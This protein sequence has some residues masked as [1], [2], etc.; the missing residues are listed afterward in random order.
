MDL[1]LNVFQL[2]Q[3]W[4]SLLWQKLT[5]LRRER[6]KELNALA[7]IFGDPV[8]LARFY[9]EPDCQQV[10][11][12]D[13]LEDEAIVR[14]PL[15]NRIQT[16]ISGA[17]TRQNN[18]LFILSDAGMGKT[19]ALLM[20]KLGHMM[21]FWPKDYDCVLL[22]LGSKSLEDI[23]AVNEK[24]K[25]VLLLDALDEDPTAWGH[26]AER[27]TDILRAT[28][29][30]LRVIITCRTQFFQARHDPFNRRGQVE[31]GGFLCPVVYASLF[32]DQQVIQYIRLRFPT[33]MMDEAWVA[34]AKYIVNKM[35]FLRMRPMLLAHLPDLMESR[36]NIWN[37]YSIYR[38]LVDAWLLREQRKA[39]END[40][41][42]S[43]RLRLACRYAAFQMHQS[44]RAYFSRVETEVLN[45][46]AG[47][48]DGRSIDL[49]GRSL[50]NRDSNGNYR[51]SHY[52]IQ[53]FLVLEYL[54]ANPTVAK[55]RSVR[56][57]DFMNQ[58]AVAW[59]LQASPS[60]RAAVDLAFINFSGAHLDDCHLQ[61][62]NFSN[63]RMDGATFRNSDLSYANL[64]GTSLVG[65]DLCGAKLAATRFD[66]ADIKGATFADT[67]VEGAVFHLAMC[68]LHTRWPHSTPLLHLGAI[69]P[70]K[71][72]D[73]VARATP[74]TG[75]DANLP[76]VPD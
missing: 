56:T 58:M 19:S 53:E 24:R 64:K 34:R 16:F 54:L 13:Y 61:G 26:V 27:L 11:P 50:L 74:A 57:T 66:G 73:E 8:E 70:P 47:A 39:Y 33:E 23:S 65:T 69:S 60:E 49:G 51:F 9:I 71:P 55:K 36:E 67:Q 15:F 40:P 22:K 32:T 42:Y 12:A 44:E 35:G 25:T 29:P 7:D 41:L 2:A 59:F 14:E 75:V 38:A 63:C 48:T 6:E 17:S 31:I 46:V 10:N 68:D 72:S 20:L 43:D 52:S 45:R 30:F 3:G 62:V 1:G 37:E 21:S 18:Q 5:N 4:V 28:K 76:S